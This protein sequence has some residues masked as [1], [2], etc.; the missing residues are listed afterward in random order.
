M[1]KTTAEIMADPAASKPRQNQYLKREL[2]IPGRRNRPQDPNAPAASQWPLS[3]KFAAQKALTT[4]S[5]PQVVSTTFTGAT[6]ADSSSFPPDTMGAVGPT[7]FI[8]FVNGRLRTFN[9]GTGAHDGVLNADPDQFFSSV[10]TPETFP[11]INYTTDPQIRYDRLS[12]RWI[13][14]IIDVPSS[15]RSKAGDLPNRILIAVSDAASAGIIS[16]STMW[17]FYFVQQNTLGGGN[18]SEFLDYPSLGVDNNALYIGANMF[19]AS[20]GSFTTTSAFV[21]RKSSILNGGPIV[22]T[23]FRNL[24]TSDGPASPRGVD[25]YDPLA[26]EGYIIGASNGAFGRLIL[27]RITNPGG[28]P[29]ISPDIA[30][31]VNSTSSPIDVNHLGNTAG[32]AGQLD[33]LDDRLFAAHIRNGRLWT[34]H[35]IAVTATGVASSGD[36]QRRDAV[37]WYEL[38]V[39][40]GSGT[41][42]VVQSGTVF[43]SASTVAAARQYWIPSVVVSGQGHTALGFSTAGSPYRIDAATNG[44]LATD[45]FGSLGTPT[46]YSSSST[47]Y[48]PPS[49]PGPTRRWG[50][51]SF[52]SLD[53]NDDMT[54]WTIQQFCDA[55][56][57]FGVRVA[58]LVAPPPATPA[59][60]NSSVA[61]GQSSVSVTI[62]GT[63]TSGSGFFDPGVGFPN[64][65]NASVSGGVVVNSVTYIDPTHVTLNLNTTGA[66][67]GASNVT[68]IN[69]DGQFRTGVGV[70]NITTP[71]LLSG[72]VS[73][74]NHIGIGAFDINLPTSGAIGI[75]NRSDGTGQ[76][77]IVF[78]FNHPVN[79][80]D[81]AIISGSAN[82]DMVTYSGN[83][84]IVNLS[85]VANQ[86]V[87]GLTVSNITDTSSNILNSISVNVGFL[88][89]DTTGDGF[90]NSGDIAQTKSESGNVVTISNFR[91]DVNLDGSLNSGDIA[92]VKSTSGTALP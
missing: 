13:L 59:S 48:N 22:A 21:V 11:R 38:N 28:T 49:D 57:S 12:G 41:P 5:A 80:G 58:K 83:D 25:N 70:L 66:S 10:L 85:G 87:L 82:I 16:G 61:V 92:F 79:G 32:T 19:N 31:T 90:V 78:T 17:T 14:V 67:T 45:T 46:L 42:V 18:T 65:I 2:E 73:R 77:T 30:I 39:P 4:P 55:T 53:P 24:L 47:A 84:I 51:Y 33:A 64:H 34:A 74:K 35:N 81:A 62:T 56:N 15:S 91:E 76:Y 63:S 3:N 40:V 89:G 50:D 37:R 36:P 88:A 44:R 52:T 71:F 60:A 27:R 23:A 68:I 20:S 29:S 8:V 43:D 54:M 69:P 6:L 7:Q 26:N 75:E 86:Q 1:Q 72:I 9:K